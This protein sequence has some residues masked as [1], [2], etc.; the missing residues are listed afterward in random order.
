MLR[1]RF[2]A[3]ERRLTAVIERLGEIPNTVSAWAQD[4]AREL[5]KR[6]Y[7]PRSLDYVMSQSKRVAAAHDASRGWERHGRDRGFSR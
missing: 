5:G 2:D 4:L 7:N 1:E 6:V 3:L